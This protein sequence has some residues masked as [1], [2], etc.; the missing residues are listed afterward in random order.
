[1]TPSFS[2]LR[3]PDF[4]PLL[5]PPMLLINFF[6]LQPLFWLLLLYWQPHAVL[7]FPQGSSS[8]VL[9]RRLED[10]GP[11]EASIFHLHLRPACSLNFR[12]KVQ[13][14]TRC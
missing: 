2:L 3:F 6:T 12:G 4:L 8:W 5:Q 11:T 14:P 10:F 1:M 9:D 7:S 13:P